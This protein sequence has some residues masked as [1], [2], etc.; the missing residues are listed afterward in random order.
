MFLFTQQKIYCLTYNKV[1]MLKVSSIKWLLD[2]RR[3]ESNPRNANFDDLPFDGDEI[4]ITRGRLFCINDNI[5]F[6]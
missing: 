2:N 1:E 5:V 3:Y 4:L 6:S